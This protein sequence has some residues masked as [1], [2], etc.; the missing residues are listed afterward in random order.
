MWRALPGEFVIEPQAGQLPPPGLLAPVLPVNVFDTQRE[1]QRSLDFRFAAGA[2][3]RVNAVNFQGNPITQLPAAAAPAC[4]IGLFLVVGGTIAA[5]PTATA[6][7]GA[8]SPPAPAVF[9][10]PPGTDVVTK[11]APFALAPLSTGANLVTVGSGDDV[12]TDLVFFRPEVGAPAEPTARP[13]VLTVRPGTSGTVNLLTNDT[14]SA[15]G[16]ALSISIVSGPTQGQ[17]D[18]GAGGSV[19]YTAAPNAS[20]TDSVTYDAVDPWGNRSRNTLT[21][22]IQPWA[23]LGLTVTATPT[24][25]A[26]GGLFEYVVT[27][28]NPSPTERARGMRLT[29]VMPPGAGMTGLTQQPPLSGCSFSPALGS[30]PSGTPAVTVNCSFPDLAPNGATTFKVQAWALPGSAGTSLSAAAT[31][32]SSDC[33][34]VD[35]V[36]TGSQCLAP[37]VGGPTVTSTTLVPEIVQVS[38]AAGTPLRVGDL[39]RQRFRVTNTGGIAAGSTRMVVTFPAELGVTALTQQPALC[40]RSFSP[41]LGGTAAPTPA[42]TV[43]CS[44]GDLAPGGV[45]DLEIEARVLDVP[46]A[47]AAPVLLDVSSSD[48]PDTSPRAGVQCA[49][50]AGGPGVDRV[51]LTPAVRVDRVGGHVVRGRRRRTRRC[52]GHQHQA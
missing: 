46:V 26:I 5:A 38:P 27:A 18:V 7:F 17:L 29:F 16:E 12:T 14:P 11:T 44:L 15:P 22:T 13:D 20:G 35:P 2:T 3:V 43:S 9:R 36:A 42:V 8:G 33:L 1:L 45:R 28:T 6:C 51:N 30:G 47:P 4:E 37:V 40:S 21:I 50:T 24:P 48:C 52:H 41:A 32:S 39:V 23:Q 31:L 49:T 25:V 19:T 34:D 10:V